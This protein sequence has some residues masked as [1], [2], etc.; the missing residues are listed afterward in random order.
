[1]LRLFGRPTI[2]PRISI[3]PSDTAA[4]IAL[5]LAYIALFCAAIL[6]ARTRMR[7]RIVVA[8]LLATSTLHVFVAA[9]MGGAS[10]RIH[11]AFVNPN[12]LAGYLQIGLAF[13]FGVIWTEVLTGSDRIDAIRDSAERLEKRA[14][15]FV[16]RI[17]LWGILATGMVLSRSRG[18]ML[19]AAIATIVALILGTLGSRISLRRPKVAAPAIGA[20][21]LGLVFVFFTAGA[22]P[23]MP[24]TSEP[25]CASRSGAHRSTP[26]D[27]FR[28]SARDSAL[29]AKRSAGYSRQRSWASRKRRTTTSFNCS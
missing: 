23:L 19:A 2:V 15:P 11:G 27:S 1:V 10:E 22:T 4:T 5:T 6:L 18:G 3:V 29:F 26:G 12:H 21:V 13:A 24:A 8:V 25:T 7:R 20:I 17:L 14:L 28:I 9:I 16:W